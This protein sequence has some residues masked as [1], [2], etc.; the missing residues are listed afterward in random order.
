M[1]SNMLKSMLLSAGAALALAGCSGA[2]DIGSA[3]SGNVTVNNN[4]G[5]SG[6]GT[7]TPPPSNLV[8]PAA[9]CPTIDDPQGLKDDGTITGPT[10]SYR[11][12]TLPARINRTIRLT[13]VTGLLYQLAGRVDV[14]ADGGF[15]ASAADT[16]VVLNIDPGVIIFGGT[17]QSWLAV[18]RGNR[19]NAVGTAT[20]PIIFTSRDNVLGLNTDTSQGQ[21]GG[22]VLMG[23]GRVT[24]CTTG[25]VA[26]GTCERQTEGAADPARFGGNNDADNSGRMSFVQIRYS[27]FVLGANS[28]LQ[29][30][31]TEAVGSATILDHIMSFNSSDD[32]SEHF[33]GSPNMKYYVSVGA[34]DDSLDVDTGAQMNVQFGLLIQRPGAGDALLEIDSNGFETDTPRTKLTI[35]NFTMLQPQ[36]TSNNEANDQ[37]SVLFRGNSDVTLVNSLLITPNNECIRMNGS[38]AVPATLTAASVALQ[39]NTAR[40]LGTGSYTAAAVQAQFNPA[41]NNNRDTFTSTLSSQFINGSNETGVPAFNVTSL[42]TFFTAVS[43]IGAVSGAGDTWYQGW[44]CNSSTA[45]FGTGSNCT[46]LPTN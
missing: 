44:T 5:T 23:R 6:G 10:G 9:G 1:K 4:G 16:N 32:G 35:S 13:K 24:D 40:Y 33:G 17:G 42:G 22:V 31:T 34:D 25:S 26:A 14:G 46:S 7:T 30:L 20:Q 45:N 29:S 36:V 39:C 43:Y 27:G 3:G 11:V 8:T 21:W 12:C 38:G 19:I 37:A 15:T 2:G 28:E 18:N 41:M